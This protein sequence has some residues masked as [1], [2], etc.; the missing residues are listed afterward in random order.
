MVLMTPAFML[1]QLLL[2]VGAV[3]FFGWLA[4][5]YVRTRELDTVNRVDSIPASELA[6]LQDVI[7]SLQSEVSAIRERQEFLEKLLER[8]RS[9]SGST[10]E[11]L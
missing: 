6:K 4:L 3:G 8:P 10:P 5:R 9:S 1:F 7:T 2:S 11:E